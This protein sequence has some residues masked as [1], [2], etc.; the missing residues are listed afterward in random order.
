MNPDLG[1][2]FDGREAAIDENSERWAEIGRAH[3]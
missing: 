2:L 1:H 3:V